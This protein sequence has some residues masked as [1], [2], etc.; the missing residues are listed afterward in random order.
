MY[1]NNLPFSE[2]LQMTQ[3]DL[4]DINTLLLTPLK[5]QKNITKHKKIAW[6]LCSCAEHAAGITFGVLTIIET[7]NHSYF[8]GG[9]FGG[10]MA[11]GAITGFD[12]GK[13]AKS[14]SDTK[15]QLNTEIQNIEN[16]I[17]SASPE[18]IH[19]IAEIARNIKQ[20]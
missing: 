20:R 4:Y 18:Q 16:I 6:Q 7:Y 19:E 9:I 1:V 10:L 17:Q 13:Q 2:T 14:Y 11:I 15:K 3:C 5:K 12:A 8:M